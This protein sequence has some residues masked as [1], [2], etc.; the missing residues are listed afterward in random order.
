MNDRTR[1]GRRAL[2]VTLVLSAVAAAPAAAAPVSVTLRVE[3]SSQTIY[4]DRVTTDGHLVTTQSGG[5]HKCD[6]TNGGAHPSPVP[7][8][9]A[10]L[11]DGSRT[12][13][14]TWDGTYNTSF[15]DFLVNRVG[16]D[17]ASSSQ[18]WAFLV[19]SQFSQTGG[20]QTRVGQ[21]DEVLWAYDGFNKSSVLRLE[22]PASARTG[23]PVPVRVTDGQDGAPEPGARVG[24]AVTG[25]DGR[26]T[27]VF[28]DPGIYRLKAERGDAIRSNGVS[29]C[30]DPEGAPPCTSTDKAAPAASVLF[31][32]GYASDRSRTRT[33]V[34]SWQGE[35]SRDGSGVSSYGLEVREVA[36]G[37]QHAQEGWRTLIGQ[38]TLTTARF[39]AAPGSTYE[40]RVHARDRAGNRGE[41]T[42]PRVIVP[43]DDRD[44]RLM[45][46]SRGWRRLARKGA[47]GRTVLRPRFAGPSLRFRFRGTR[48]AVIGRRLPRRGGRLR[49]TVGGRSRV[50]RLRG[51]SGF[52]RVLFTSRRLSPGLHSARLTAAGGRI[53]IDAL[54]PIP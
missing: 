45:R 23:Q 47:W 36:A 4:E 24:G 51:R 54:A 40:F 25:G 49:V 19:N 38:T 42:S 22:G 16:P 41:A 7:V 21:N 30:V 15:D 48:L 11:D 20:C 27:L 14:F 12:G 33:L 43:V 53:E 3:G 50:V 31:R 26:A 6:G 37:A 39:R 32:G 18:F 17:S 52:R 28:P 29:L 35:D 44:R 13:A 46:L 34:V 8:A 10:A 9:T 2:A 1:T 5:T